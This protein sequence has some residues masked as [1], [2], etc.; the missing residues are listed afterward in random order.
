STKNRGGSPNYGRPGNGGRP[1]GSGHNTGRPGNGGRPNGSGHNT[2]RPGNGGRPNGSGHNNNGH[3]NNGHHGHNGH[4]NNGHHGHNGHNNNGHHGHNGHN[5]NG[6]HG[7]NGHNNNGH[8]PNNGHHGR[9]GHNYNSYCNYSNHNYGWN[10]IC[11]A[12][13][14]IGCRSIRGFHDESDRFRAARRFVRN[15]YVNAHQI[16]DIM[17]MFR[18]ESTKLEFAKY[19]FHRTCD[20]QNYG[21]VFAQLTY[22]S[23]RRDLDCYV[24]DFQW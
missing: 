1:N 14:S 11:R 19:A 5:N 12:D 16:A 3:N 6:H 24:R 8:R 20:I 15:N 2:G 10:P 21:I 9:H 7:H 23:S 22:K 18:H 4:N 13:F 17:M